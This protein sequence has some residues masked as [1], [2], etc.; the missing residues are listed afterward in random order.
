MN[1]DHLWVVHVKLF[2]GVTM[3]DLMDSEE[4]RGKYLYLLC[5]CNFNIWWKYIELM[6]YGNNGRCVG[7]VH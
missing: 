7:I 5:E 6:C 3:N 2:R 4:G 1:V